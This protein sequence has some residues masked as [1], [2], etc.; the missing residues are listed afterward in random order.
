MYDEDFNRYK[1]YRRIDWTDIDTWEFKELECAKREY[2]NTYFNQ[3]RLF[4]RLEFID[5]AFEVLIELYKEGYDLTIC[6]L[7]F[8]PN[9]SLKKDWCDKHLPFIKQEF[10]NLK[11]HKDKSHIDMSNAFFIDDNSKLLNNSNA[12]TKICF[13][14]VAGWN[15]D[16]QG[17][18]CHNWHD[19]KRILKVY[20]GE[21]Y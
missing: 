2:I 16:W 9:L 21:R 6:T 18:R 1:K 10:I 14:D 4:N 7:G 17:L 15:R 20:E 19:V 8:S 12:R 5:N 3:E 13:G 11:E